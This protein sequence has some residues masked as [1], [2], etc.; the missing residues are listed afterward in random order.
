MEG[1]GRD[2]T[3][4][5]KHTNTRWSLLHTDEHTHTHTYVQGRCQRTYG[6]C[7]HTQTLSVRS[8]IGSERTI[9]QRTVTPLIRGDIAALSGQPGGHY[10]HRPYHKFTLRVIVFPLITCTT[11]GLVWQYRTNDLYS[12]MCPLSSVVE[13]GVTEHNS[14]GH[15]NHTCFL[16]VRLLIMRYNDKMPCRAALTSIF[17]ID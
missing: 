12:L 3:H 17:I 15:F 4:I 5:H 2:I 10:Y 11:H 6:P 7:H 13:E 9:R 8:L 14:A 16:M 1:R